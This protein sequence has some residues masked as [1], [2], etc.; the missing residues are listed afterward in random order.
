MRW[1]GLGLLLLVAA[2]QAETLDLSGTWEFRTDPSDRGLREG[3]SAGSPAEGW[4][5]VPVPSNWNTLRPEW[6]DHEGV[7]WYRREF[8]LGPAPSHATLAF[9]GANDRARVWMNGIE[10]GSHEGG[11]TNFSLDVASAL[12]PGKNLLVVRLDNS[13]RWDGV[14]PGW[15]GF[16]N[17]GGL[18]R[19]VRLES[20]A[21]ANLPAPRLPLLEVRGP[22]LLLDGAPLRLRG[23][24][25]HEEHP[26]LG[27]AFNESLVRRDFGM[28]LAAGVNFVRLSHY[29][30][31]PRVLDIADEMGLWVME[32]IP[33]YW[34]SAAQMADP[35]V[36]ARAEQQLREMILRD[37]H[38]PSVLLWGVANEVS[39]HTPEGEEFLCH[40][41]RVARELDPARPV[42]FAS[43]HPFAD[44]AW[45][46]V[47][48]V[49]FNEYYGWY[50]GSLETLKR[51]LE[52]ATATGKP[53]LVTEFGADGVPGRHG[54][55]K[56]SEE[57]QAK[58]IA[59]H[60]RLINSTPGLLGGVV[61]VWADFEDPVRP[62]NPVP[63]WNM[64]GVVTAEREPKPA[65]RVLS[66]LYHGREPQI[67]E[68]AREG[69]GPASWA[70]ALGAL[71]SIPLLLRPGR[72]LPAWA[73]AALAGGVAGLAL[74][75]GLSAVMARY[76]L[77]LLGPRWLLDALVTLLSSPA[78]VAVGALFAL[79]WAGL[80]GL[81]VRWL[82][83]R[84]GESL[85]VAALF[86]IPL[87]PLVAA[88][89]VAPA[90][91]V[92]AVAGGGGVASLALAVWQ[93]RARCGLSWPRSL[94]A[95]LAPGAILGG[96][97]TGLLL[98]YFL[99]NFNPDWL[100]ALATL[101]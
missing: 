92:L 17:F 33:A 34:L 61:W 18:Y 91:A 60:W 54:A 68:A 57:F 58:F 43:N 26:G 80:H 64:K 11:Y 46:C 62:L 44:R 52:S 10:V 20:G 22:Q 5:P 48:V 31:H 93:T 13:R 25:L 37:R 29:P 99:A 89:A 66:D 97:V 21:P 70:A 23:V 32:E 41:A 24:A 85:R 6:R 86:T 14:P 4:T 36:R 78:A 101:K 55:G 16:G 2:V 76:P 79:S 67:P 1:S 95:A 7:A 65:Y 42:T 9:L 47:D 45:G 39:S 63:Y 73:R 56:W 30:H 83:G 81:L 50:H 12:R 28:M 38:H 84:G 94:V 53:V 77:A 15:Y 19:E 96:L 75:F 69:P 27:R 40:L 51:A 87:L 82:K 90:P 49:A 59:D 3:W 72:N 88:L 8:T 74:P 98:L 100:G 35:T 71:G